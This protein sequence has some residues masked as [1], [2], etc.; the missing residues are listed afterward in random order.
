V[1]E[2]DS[3]VILRLVQTLQVVLFECYSVSPIPLASSTIVILHDRLVDAF[4]AT[5]HHFITPISGIV[6]PNLP[7]NAFP[8]Q[9]AKA[10]TKCFQNN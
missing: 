3:L 4:V 7:K 6:A 10:Q 1:L 5:W 8:F 9:D 2:T